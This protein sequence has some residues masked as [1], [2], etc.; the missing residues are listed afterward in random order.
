MLLSQITINFLPT[1]SIICYS[2]TDKSMEMTSQKIMGI[3]EEPT[4][5]KDVHKDTFKNQ[6]R[7]RAS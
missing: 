5:L 2:C 6:E 1:H 3:L 4:L 7:E